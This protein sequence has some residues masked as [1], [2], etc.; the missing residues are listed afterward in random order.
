MSALNGLGFQCWSQSTTTE[1]PNI[2]LI[3]LD[4][5]SSDMFS[6]EILDAFYPNIASMA[7][8]GIRFSNVHATTP[9]CAPS[10]ASLFRGQYAFNTGIKVN[11]PNSNNSNGFTGGYAEF[12]ARGYR[13]N[14]LG[15]WM[16]NAGYR[17]LHVGKFHHAQFDGEKPSGWDEVRISIGNQYRGG[18]RFISGNDLA[19]HYIVTG[20][21]DYVTTMDRNDATELI[22]QQSASDSPFFLY[23]APLAPHAP[24]SFVPEDMVEARYQDFASSHVMPYTPD[25]FEQDISDKPKHHQITLSQQNIELIQR[26]YFA[27]LRAIKSID[28]LVGQVFASLEEIGAAENTYVFLTSDNGFQTGHHNLQGKIDSFHRTTNVPLFA[29]GPGVVANQ[30]ADHLLAHIDIC[31]TILNLAQSTVPENV[32]AKSFF[33]LLFAPTDFDSE[34][35]QEGI[36]IENWAKRRNFGSS[37]LGTYLAWRSHHEVFVSWAN[38]EFEYYDLE[39]DPYQLK[40][41]YDSLPTPEKQN[42]KRLVRRFRTRS[43]DPITT[44]DK[45]YETRFQNRKVKLRGYAED[46]SG[47]HGTEIVV[48]SGTT[49]RY[50]NGES[51]QD[52]LFTHF[53]EPRNFNQ[54]ISVWSYR[55]RM[56]TE[57]ESGRDIIVFSYRSFDA[58]N[59]FPVDV[60]FH[61]NEIDGKSPVASFNEFAESIPE[62]EENVTFGGNYF[63]GLA[64]DRA[65]VTIR[66]VVTNQ[67]FD[68]EQFQNNRVN[69]NTELVS[70]S[71]WQ[72]NVQLPPGFYIAGVKGIDAAGN[73]QHPADLF[74]FRVV[75][76]P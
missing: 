50:W 21:D 54:P 76:S 19:S 33:P 1:Q 10:R 31:P 66:D 47:I 53:L 34:T 2:V 17:T 25:L 44:V 36:M 37:I 63:D 70:D 45:K 13:E 8:N 43:T 69:L 64:F 51:W 65:I 12:I 42:L 48:R 15:V 4:D 67:Y 27:R 68:G 52:E 7:Q 29:I 11:N 58:S 9:F 56:E 39:T 59:E 49:Q 38:G 61:V 16:Q 57:T 62:F 18:Q 73:R 41:S 26:N 46:D 35:W 74:R 55:T 20:E 3:N 23:I 22:L 40:N 71:Q 60:S 28:D 32:E 6:S 72:L 75:D 24:S 14:E 5:A 30:T